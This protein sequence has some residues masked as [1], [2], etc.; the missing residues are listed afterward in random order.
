MCHVT[1]RLKDMP[2]PM[3]LPH[4]LT[5]TQPQRSTRRDITTEEDII[6]LVEK[7]L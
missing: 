1:M 7:H 3:P 4:S 2:M 5:L 6:M